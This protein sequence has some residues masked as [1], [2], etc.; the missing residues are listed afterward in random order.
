MRILENQNDQPRLRK[1][2]R[3]PTKVGR[4]LILL[5]V[6][7]KY[8]HVKLICGVTDPRRTSAMKMDVKFQERCM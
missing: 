8:C 5:A 3:Y 4:T 2:M 1:A 7:M 6:S